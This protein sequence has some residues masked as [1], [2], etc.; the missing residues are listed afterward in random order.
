[1]LHQLME[2]LIRL[3]LLGFSYL[4]PIEQA[5]LLL[6][7]K[8]GFIFNYCCATETE[9]DYCARR[10]DNLPFSIQLLQTELPSTHILHINLMRE[11]FLD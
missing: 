3:F 5:M 8:V 1:M 6:N 9:Q 7:M 4:K 2:C 11:P 10:N